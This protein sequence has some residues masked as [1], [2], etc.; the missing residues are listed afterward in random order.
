MT[1]KIIPM[2]SVED[3][4]HEEINDRILTGIIGAQQRVTDLTKTISGSNFVNVLQVML[5]SDIEAEQEAAISICTEIK[6]LEAIAANLQAICAHI[7]FAVKN[8][9][10]NLMKDGGA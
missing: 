10:K 9:I 7:R 6:E 8:D 2:S 1:G 3:M 4:T 5:Q